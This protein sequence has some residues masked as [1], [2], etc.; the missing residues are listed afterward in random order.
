MSKSETN[1]FS[2]SDTY[3]DDSW[4]IASPDSFG[5]SSSKIE[6]MMTFVRENTFFDSLIAVKS[7]YI[8]SEGYQYSMDENSTKVIWGITKGIT[9]ILTLIAISNG[10]IQSL[11]SKVFDY[12]Q[13][14]N[15]SNY[16][17]AKDDITIR[18]I[19]T[20]SSGLDWQIDEIRYTTWLFSSDKI[21]YILDLP[22]IN[23]PG[24]TYMENTGSMH[25]LTA[26]INITTGMYPI[27]FAKQYLFDPL[28][29]NDF[30]WEKDEI[31]V[32]FGGHG[33]HMRSRDL[34]KLG[35]L[36]LRN[37]SWEGNQIISEDMM[38]VIKTPVWNL[39]LENNHERQYGYRFYHFPDYEAF[40]TLGSIMLSITV[41][42]DLDMVL[43]L[44]GDIADTKP[45]REYY[46]LL[47]EYIYPA[48]TE[49]ALNESSYFSLLIAIFV[50]NII[51]HSRKRRK[52]SALI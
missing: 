43:V 26:I 2:L 13:D 6:D 41:L 10:F 11:D 22:L 17:S 16:D 38:N 23:E 9:S 1:V 7:G 44:T 52:K 27:T 3:P 14:R 28:G 45:P 15:I 32:N 30:V 21:Q 40:A 31:N 47:D 42:S 51:L 24:S 18:H 5:L 35:Y 50:L 20:S 25:L 39:S 46:V 48:H 19:L 37:G 8:I 34:A 12:F 4:E 29:I 49:T 33:L 36:L